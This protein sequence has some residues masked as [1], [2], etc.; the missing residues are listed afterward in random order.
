MEEVKL[1]IKPFYQK[2]EVT[3]EE[4]K[5]ILRKAVQK[6]GCARACVWG[7]GSRAAR[8]CCLVNTDFG[9]TVNAGPRS[10]SQGRW[11]CCHILQAWGQVG[12]PVAAPGR[13]LGRRVPQCLRGPRRRVLQYVKLPSPRPAYR[14]ENKTPRVSRCLVTSQPMLPPTP[15]NPRWPCER[16]SEQEGDLP[17]QEGRWGGPCRCLRAAPGA[18]F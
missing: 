10:A 4:Y 16:H 8:R 2:R 15:W 17:C 12:S 14:W 5:D 3:K 18:C 13:W 11:L 9:V 1:A 7:S 6:V